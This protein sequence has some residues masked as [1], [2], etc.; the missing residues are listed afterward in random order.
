MAYVIQTR[1][2]PDRPNLRA[3]TRAEHLAFLDA[4]K[5]KL[6][7]GGAVINDD[8]TGGHGGVI[9]LDTDDR[10]EAEKF[11]ADDPFTKAGLFESITVTRW[12]KAFFNFEKLI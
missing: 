5:D 6:L 9:I 2:K 7:A 4:N 12:R 8:G 3:E 11:I 1:D 10:E